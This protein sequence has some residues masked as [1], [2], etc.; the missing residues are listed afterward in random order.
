MGGV[1]SGALADGRNSGGAAHVRG[2]RIAVSIR[3]NDRKVIEEDNTLR[4]H[5][6]LGYLTPAQFLRQLSSQPKE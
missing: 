4:P 2:R 6:S 1:I 3:V 5:Q